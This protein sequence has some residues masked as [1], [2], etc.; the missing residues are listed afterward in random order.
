[1]YQ[2]KY[3]QTFFQVML[4]INTDIHKICSSDGSDYCLQYLYTFN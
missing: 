4:A 2:Y 1:M 3:S